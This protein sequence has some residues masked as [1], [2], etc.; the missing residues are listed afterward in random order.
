V[1]IVNYFDA[2][3]S[4]QPVL[5]TN[6]AKAIVARLRIVMEAEFL[7]E[8]LHAYVAVKQVSLAL[9][10]GRAKCLHP[11]HQKCLKISL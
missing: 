2:W 9:R 11:S 8:N 4:D 1:V 7:A 10:E 5:W 3:G 6:L